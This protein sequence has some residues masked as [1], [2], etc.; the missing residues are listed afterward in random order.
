MSKPRDSGAFLLVILSALLYAASLM[1]PHTWWCSFLF[2]IPL[3]YA[4]LKF[5]ITMQYGFAWGIIAYSLLCSFMVFMLLD[6]AQGTWRL[7][8]FPILVGYGTCSSGLWFYFTHLSI[9]MCGRKHVFLWLLSTVL[10]F[11]W[12]DSGMFIIFGVFEGNS[13]F[14]PLL[15]FMRIPGLLY[16]AHRVSKYFILLW[17]CTCAMMSALWLYT[18]RTCYLLIA[19]SLYSFFFLGSCLQHVEEPPLWLSRVGVIQPHYEAGSAIP[20]AREITYDMIRLCERYPTIHCIFA[21]ESTF[22]YPLNIQVQ[23]QEMWRDNVLVDQVSFCCGGY[24]SEQEA[25][26]NSLFILTK[27]Q[28]MCCHDKQHLFCFTEHIPPLWSYIPGVPTLFLHKGKS[29]GVGSKQRKPINIPLVGFFVPYLCSELL[30]SRKPRDEF[31]AVPI[32][33][34]ANDSW[35]RQD[36][37]PR[38]MLLQAQWKAL[39]WKRPI[40]YVAYRHAA[41]IDTYGNTHTLQT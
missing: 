6:Y 5:Q 21:P 15:P 10:Y 34:L 28:D 2:L 22:A 37:M 39:E 36:Y 29:F 23:A 3:Y 13:F 18:L 1:L 35:F 16:S 27:D 30:L 32:V 9:R 20:Q 17:L 4:T 24:R 7:L 31:T 40:L 25:L 8:G 11:W 19:V 41:W 38:L 33:C 14:S 26:Y 12:V